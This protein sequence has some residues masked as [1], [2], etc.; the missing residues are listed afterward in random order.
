MNLNCPVGREMANGNLRCQAGCTDELPDVQPIAD[1]TCE[2][3]GTP[4]SRPRTVPVNS[5]TNVITEYGLT[6]RNPCKV[7]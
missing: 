7:F 1:D 6:S 4:L 3:C 5:V 2:V